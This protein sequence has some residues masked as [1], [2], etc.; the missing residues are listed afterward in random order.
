MN[1]PLLDTLPKVSVPSFIIGIT[2]HKKG[3]CGAPPLGPHNLIASNLTEWCWNIP[4][5][6]GL[7]LQ[8]LSHSNSG[9]ILLPHFDVNNVFLALKL[10]DLHYSQYADRFS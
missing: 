4:N 9:E 7:A 3:E 5:G 8:V 1:I 10:I 2:P 6:A